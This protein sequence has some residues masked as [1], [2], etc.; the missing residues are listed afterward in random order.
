MELLSD[1]LQC[2]NA[3][4]SKQLFDFPLVFGKC[5][6]PHIIGADKEAILIPIISYDDNNGIM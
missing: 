2:S 4:D 6:L 5:N 1:D 3:V